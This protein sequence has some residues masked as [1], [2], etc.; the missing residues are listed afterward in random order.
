MFHVD[1]EVVGKKK[2]V[3][4]TWESWKESDKSEEWKGEKQ[5]G[6]TATE[7]L[8]VSCEKDCLEVKEWELCRW[9]E[10]A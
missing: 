8:G 10:K 1:V 9:I 6:S 7:K 4:V 2:N 3:L 5:R